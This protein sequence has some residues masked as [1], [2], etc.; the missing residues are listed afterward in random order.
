MILKN[1]IHLL[2]RQGNENFIHNLIPETV[3]LLILNAKYQRLHEKIELP[4]RDRVLHEL[5]QDIRETV[6]NHIHNLLRTAVFHAKRNRLRV[7]R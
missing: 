7:R 2:L 6:P 3:K 4:Q 5:I 1:P